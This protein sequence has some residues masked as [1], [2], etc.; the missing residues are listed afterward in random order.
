MIRSIRDF[1]LRKLEI[2]VT[3]G[4]VVVP[5]LMIY[6]LSSRTQT[7]RP[8]IISVE[9]TPH[10]RAVSLPR[11]PLAKLPENFR[12][13]PENATPQEEAMYRALTLFALVIYRY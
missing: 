6:D 2:I 11:D 1:L 10:T 7:T 8:D 5:I 3:L 9:V 4:I 12:L 13:A